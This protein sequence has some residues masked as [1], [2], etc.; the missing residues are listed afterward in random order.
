VQSPVELGDISG[1]NR[2]CLTLAETIADSRVMAARP[3]RKILRRPMYLGYLFGD[4]RA[5]V[6]LRVR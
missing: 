6:P 5:A 3:L 1:S 2:N 4:L